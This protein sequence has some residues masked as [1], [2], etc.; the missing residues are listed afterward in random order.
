[1]SLE[2]NRK[3]WAQDAKNQK[4]LSLELIEKAWAQGDFQTVTFG[5]TER[6]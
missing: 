2:L 5:S 1:L 3:A 6:Q 4:F